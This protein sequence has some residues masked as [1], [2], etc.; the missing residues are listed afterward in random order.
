ME[1][2]VVEVVFEVWPGSP[3]TSVAREAP[4]STQHASEHLSTNPSLFNNMFHAHKSTSS[5]GRFFCLNFCPSLG[6]TCPVNGDL[7]NTFY[8]AAFFNI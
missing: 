1:E 7:D 5:E 8:S 3:E 4:Q 6:F 2:E